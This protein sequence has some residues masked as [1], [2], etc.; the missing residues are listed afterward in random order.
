MQA[1]LG[2][3]QETNWDPSISS[4]AFAEFCEAI[5]PVDNATVATAQGITVKSSTYAYAQYI[6]QVR[7]YVML[8]SR[9]IVLK[10]ASCFPRADVRVGVSGGPAGRSA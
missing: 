7:A 6:N 4:D 10:F 5:G 8:S 2:N 9:G 3:W 1:P